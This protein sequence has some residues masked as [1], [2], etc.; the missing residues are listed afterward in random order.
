M[1]TIETPITDNDIDI[2]VITLLNG[3][4]KHEAVK[5]IELPE[6]KLKENQ[7]LVGVFVNGVAAMKLKRDIDNDLVIVLRSQP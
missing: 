4:A 1:K 5:L 7:E 3:I 6:Y 2:H